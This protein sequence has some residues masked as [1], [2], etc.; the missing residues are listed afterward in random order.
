M[1][2]ATPH[3]TISPLTPERQV[4]FSPSANLTLHIRET[5]PELN[6][7]QLSSGAWCGAVIDDEPLSVLVHCCFDGTFHAELYHSAEGRLVTSPPSPHWDVALR[8]LADQVRNLQRAGLS[9]PWIES[10]RAALAI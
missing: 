3:N 2:R 8:E 5:F 7:K 1:T 9:T 4:G 6:W 10:V